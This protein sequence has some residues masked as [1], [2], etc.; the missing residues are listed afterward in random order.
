MLSLAT[1][2]SIIISA[3]LLGLVEFIATSRAFNAFLTSPLE[4]LAKYL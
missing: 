4:A 1:S 3:S 2:K